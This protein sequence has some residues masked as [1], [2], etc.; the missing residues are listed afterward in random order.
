ML[1]KWNNLW[2]YSRTSNGGTVEQLIV[3]QWNRYG[4]T[5]EH[6]MVE[7]KHLMVEKLNISWCNS[8]KEM[9]EE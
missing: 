5:V 9:A 8:G 2:W 3:E 6:M 7:L 1:E 4:Q